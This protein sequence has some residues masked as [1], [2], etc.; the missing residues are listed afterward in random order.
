MSL[1]TITLSS[2]GGTNQRGPADN[3]SSSPLAVRP[4]SCSKAVGDQPTDRAAHRPLIM[5]PHTCPDCGTV[6]I[7][8]ETKEKEKEKAAAA[9]AAAPPPAPPPPPTPGGGSGGDEGGFPMS[10]NWKRFK[11]LK[12]KLV[13]VLTANPLDFEHPPTIQEKDQPMKVI[14]V[15]DETAGFPED[16][17]GGINSL[18]MLQAIKKWE[19]DMPDMSL[20]VHGGSNHPLN[21]IEEEGIRE[22][23]AD[24]L[25]SRPRF[26]DTYFDGQRDPVEGWMAATNAWRNPAFYIGPNYKMPEFSFTPP[27]TLFIDAALQAQ[28]DAELIGAEDR[29]N[30]EWIMDA[31]THQVRADIELFAPAPRLQRN[32]FHARA[33]RQSSAFFACNPS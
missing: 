4:T 28:D 9:A 26:N 1:C 25:K 21:L 7:I 11:P 24:W 18:F 17:P 22:R 14:W 27:H 19:L 16:N 5:P 15:P 2:N 29:V 31:V 32:A 20:V 33:L 10:D 12:K 13:D 3:P 30:S 6:C 8:C 23:R